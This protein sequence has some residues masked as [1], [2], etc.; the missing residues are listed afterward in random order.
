LGS[1]IAFGASTPL[2][3][4][5][6]RGAGPFTTAALLYGGAAAVSA[7]RGPAR[8]TPL[9]W[10]DAPRLAIVTLLGAVAAPM[11]LAWGLQR[12]SGVIASLMLNVE[13]LFTVLLARWVWRE[14][15]GPRVAMA[16]AA[17]LGG[18][19]LLV[20]GGHAASV[21]IGWG[22][23]AVTA[24]TFAWATD[25]V[26]GRPLADRDP[27]Q[28]VFAKGLL[29]AAASFAIGRGL[30]ENLPGVRAAVLLAACGAIGYGA[31]LQLYLRA[32]R[33]VG[34]AR[35]GSV[36]AAAPFLGAALAWALGERSAGALTVLGG[37]LCAI[38]VVLHLTEAHEH[39]HSHDAVEHE[40]SH[41]HDDG[42]HNHHHDS[43]PQGE[44]S[45]RHR[46]EP[47][48]HVHAHGPDLHHRHGH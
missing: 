4:H 37:L 23:L 31:S 36:F 14:P 47:I 35:T 22:A 12:T 5:F 34:A 6:G 15:I 29:G 41:R 48:S 7:R 44:H 33:L 25:N 30:G 45:H 24:A 40:H 16:L 42:H 2:V 13:A 17:M 11:A 46:H 18:G 10:R 20:A 8:D 32:Q 26:I 39:E 19:A 27:T 28:V 21:E 3:Q 43:F 1:A 38:G 9:H